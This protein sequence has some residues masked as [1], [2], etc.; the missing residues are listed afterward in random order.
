MDDQSN[1]VNTRSR[2]DDALALLDPQSRQ[3][4]RLCLEGE[5]DGEVAVRLDLPESVVASI[6]SRSLSRVQESIARESPR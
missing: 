1:A 4:V 6:R 5:G 2:L 3:V